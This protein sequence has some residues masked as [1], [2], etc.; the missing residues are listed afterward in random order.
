MQVSSAGEQPAKE[1]LG[2][3][4]CEGQIIMMKPSFW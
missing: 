4:D 1:G 2:A 3:H